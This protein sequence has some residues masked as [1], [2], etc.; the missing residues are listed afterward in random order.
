MSG[1]G[2]GRLRLLLCSWWIGGF[3]GFSLVFCGVV[4]PVSVPVDGLRQTRYSLGMFR[5]L[6]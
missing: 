1:V 5:V 2:G 3:W 4:L 6:G